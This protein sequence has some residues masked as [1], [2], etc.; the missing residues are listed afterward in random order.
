MEGVGGQWG[1]ES[2]IGSGAAAVR[3]G[4]A[5]AARSWREGA[6]GEKGGMLLCGGGGV[7]RDGVCAW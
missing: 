6:T 4:A 3:N 1:M 7:A 5:A 2:T